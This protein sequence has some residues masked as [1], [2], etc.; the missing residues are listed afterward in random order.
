MKVNVI[1]IGNSKGIRIPKAILEQCDFTDQ[2]DLEVRD[3]KLIIAPVRRKPR[4]GWSEAFK[5][6]KRRG[7][8]RLVVDDSID[9]EMKGW[10]W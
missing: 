2:A 9:L 4:E 5:S 7:E 3:S 10:E 6:M 8:D 1:T